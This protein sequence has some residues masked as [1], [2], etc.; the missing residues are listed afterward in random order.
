MSVTKTNKYFK[1]F[2]GWI[3]NS[4]VECYRLPQ[5]V[6]FLMSLSECFHVS[7][8]KKQTKKELM[9]WDSGKGQSDIGGRLYKLW[10]LWGKDL[11]NKAVFNALLGSITGLKRLA[12]PI[13][14]I[15][16]KTKATLDLTRYVFPRWMTITCISFEFAL[17]PCDWLL[18]CFDLA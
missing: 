7:A 16:S 12:P 11:I 6:C 5:L 18:N 9:K 15:R 1:T 4:Q 10:E 3:F 17:A 14:P 13:K 2:A 8:K